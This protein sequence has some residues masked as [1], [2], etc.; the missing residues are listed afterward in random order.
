[1][2]RI[3]N[4]AGLSLLL[5]ASISLKASTF[6]G[7][8]GNTLDIEYQVAYKQTLEALELIIMQSENPKQV[9]CE[10]NDT[11][12]GHAICETLKALSTEQKNYCQ[13]FLQ[14]NAQSLRTA[15]LRTQINWTEDIMSVQESTGLRA[16]DAVTDQ[17]NNMITLSQPKFYKLKAYERIFLLS[18]ELG[19]LISVDN[20][21]ISDEQK[22][23]PFQTSD[24]GRQL[25]N[26]I[27][28]AI[29]MDAYDNE[30]LSKYETSLNRSRAR[31]KHFISFSNYGMNLRSSDTY[32]VEKMNGAH[33]RYQYYFSGGVFG[34]FIGTSFSQGTKKILTQTEIL[35]KRVDDQIGASWRFF[36]AA[37]PLTFWGQSFGSIS[38]GAESSKH[39]YTAD[40]GFISSENSV[41]SSQAFGELAYHVPLVHGFWIDAYIAVH[42]DNYKMEIPNRS[43]EYNATTTSGIGISYAF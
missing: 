17:K 41:T 42:G 11:F 38:L 21:Y 3:F 28:S 1:M 22:I 40:D 13:T 16:A 6:V 35:Q 19:H 37:D 4:Y 34:I 10:C 33:F 12:A 31:S 7:N 15:L 20:S 43:F 5:L 26:A 32:A 9:L 14:T 25:L 2:I 39:T 27:G 29:A 36:S 18:H 23:G 24:G 8:G 30:V